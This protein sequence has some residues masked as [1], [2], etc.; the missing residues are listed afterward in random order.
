MNRPN[1]PTTTIIGD[2]MIKKGFGDKLSRQPNYKNHVEVQWFGGAKTQCMEDYIKLTMKLCPKQIFLHCITKKLPS[3][4]APETIAKN[5]INHAKNI[6]ADATKVTISGII[7][8]HHGI[9]TQFHLNSCGSHLNDKGATNLAQ[10]FR[11][12][13]SDIKFG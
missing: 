4:E 12:L 9:N 2:S 8:W 7:P 1:A 11:R 10:N 3:S 5:I 13:L 6:K